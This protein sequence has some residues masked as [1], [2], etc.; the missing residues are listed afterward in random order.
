MPFTRMIVAALFRLPW[1]RPLGDNS[2]WSLDTQLIASAVLAVETSSRWRRLFQSCREWLEQAPVPRPR[3]RF[4]IFPATNLALK[5]SAG[6]FKLWKRLGSGSIP[7]FI[8]IPGFRAQH[9]SDAGVYGPSAR[10]VD[11]YLVELG[12]RF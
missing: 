7:S 10:G 4:G 1:Q 12:Y 2:G 5:T 8:R 11:M 6:R 3:D 9:F